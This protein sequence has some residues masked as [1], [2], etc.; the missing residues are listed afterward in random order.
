MFLILTKYIPSA[1]L[2]SCNLICLSISLI[3]D[4]K[5]TNPK[6]FIIKISSGINFY[7]YFNSTLTIIEVGFGYIIKFICEVFASTSPILEVV[8]GCFKIHLKQLLALA[9]IK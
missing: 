9:S 2:G 4:F 3:R 7:W 1:S 8:Q 5:T 6:E